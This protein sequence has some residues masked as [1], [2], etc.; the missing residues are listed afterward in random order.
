MLVAI[1]RSPGPELTKCEL[2]HITRLPIDVSRALAQGRG[3]RQGPLEA[4]P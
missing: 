3:L 1:T 2:T 4:P